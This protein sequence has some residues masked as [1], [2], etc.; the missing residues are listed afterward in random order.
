MRTFFLSANNQEASMKCVRKVSQIEN[1]VK[2]F[3]QHQWYVGID[4]HKRSYAV[5]L[6]R[7]DGQTYTWTCPPDP[8]ALLATF[9]RCEIHPATIVHEA[10]PTGYH[11]PRV[12]AAA[13]IDVRVGAPSKIPRPVSAGAKSD[14]LDCRRLAEYAARDMVTSIA[15][16][17]KEEE[18]FRSLV[19]R[20][21][22]LSYQTR[23]CK[24]RIRA[25]LL[26]HEDGDGIELPTWHKS[27]VAVLLALDIPQELRY[28]LT[29]HF[30][31]LTK[32][33]RAFHIGI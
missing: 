13:G 3:E 5:A 26:F 9:T 7:T 32:Y 27:H 22:Q 16:P 11:L 17:T 15:I 6:R 25:L 20:R 1:F 28:L 14:R 29:S 24:Q 8:A 19:R 4:V 21:R 12:L 30:T 31:S 33:S 23:K 10:G 2:G 18:L